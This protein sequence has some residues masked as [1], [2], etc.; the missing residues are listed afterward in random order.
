MT[1]RAF[2]HLRVAD[3]RLGPWI[4]RAGECPIRGREPLPDL[5]GT[6]ASCILSQQLS[7]KAAATITRRLC[8]LCGNPD[9]MPRPEQILA[10]EIEEMR[11]V[12]VSRP[13]AQYLLGLAA[14]PLP[15]TSDLVELSDEEVIET[16]TAVKGIGRWSVEMLLMFDLGRPDILPVDDVGVRNGMRIVYGLV[17][18]PTKREMIALATPWA[19]YR[20]F[21]SWLMWEAL[22]G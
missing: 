8:D 18:N 2:Q 13:K 15:A 6:L 9:A 19:P 21:G 4:D 11:A 12:G 22:R 16:L 7:G 10:L 1:E 20:S 3:P 17:S 5:F 14:H